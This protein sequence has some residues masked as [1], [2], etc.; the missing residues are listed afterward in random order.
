ML[1]RID[2]GW[3]DSCRQHSLYLRADLDANLASAKPLAHVYIGKLGDRDVLDVVGRVHD[4]RHAVFGEPGC[5]ELRVA[6]LGRVYLFGLGRVRQA[7]LH[8]ADW[9]W[10]LGVSGQMNEA[11]LME[12]LG[13]LRPGVNEIMCH[14]GISDPETAERYPWGYSWD[15]ELAALTSEHVRQFIESNNIRLA[16]F[17]D[18]WR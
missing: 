6:D 18:A 14:P 3:R 13:R 8:T 9:F 17:A 7:G 5:H 16:S 12:T 15:D 11:N 4:D 10:G 2:V 1:V